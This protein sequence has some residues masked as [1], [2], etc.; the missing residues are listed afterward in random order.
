MH[1]RDLLK[2]AEL[3][4]NEPNSYD[5]AYRRA[6]R[7]V[8]WRHLNRLSKD[9]IINKAIKF[10]NEWACRLPSAHFSEIADGM[11]DAFNE[12]NPL[13]TLIE[14]ETLEDINFKGIKS[15]GDKE[16]DHF[17]II[18]SI[19]A[20]FC[21]IGHRFRWVAASK[22]LHQILP[23][24]FVMWDNPICDKLE[25]DLTTRSYVHDFLPLMQREANEAIRTYMEDQHCARDTAIHSIVEKC[26]EICGYEKT[27]AKLVDEYNWIRYTKGC[28]SSQ[29][30]RN[31]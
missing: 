12:V 10:L 19:F 17:E 26:R 7:N 25:L 6:R 2:A 5:S 27:L 4:M 22:T 13:I 3:F 31:K 18:H 1:Y 9:E 28:F 23:K 20:E 24:L 14:N 15:V 21:G 16:F 8:D 11:K 30:G 29:S